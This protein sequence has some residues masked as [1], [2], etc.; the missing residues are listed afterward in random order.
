[1]AIK[2]HDFKIAR[3]ILKNSDCKKVKFDINLKDSDGNNA[4]H[5][6][7]AHFGYDSKQ[8]AQIAVELIRKGIDINALNN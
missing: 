3:L 1:M 7:M 6:L 2:N 4:M 8:S 5:V